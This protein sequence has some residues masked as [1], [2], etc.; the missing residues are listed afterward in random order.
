MNKAD[1]DHST[2]KTN[3]QSRDTGHSTEKTKGKHE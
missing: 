2:E 3:E 1:T